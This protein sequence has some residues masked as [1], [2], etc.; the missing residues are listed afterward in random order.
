MKAI[1]ARRHHR[2][3][4]VV[5]LALALLTTGVLYAAFTPGPAQAASAPT[6]DDLTAGN[7]LFRA[8][9]ATCHGMNAQGRPGVAPSL[10]GVGA[11]AVDFQVSTG[12]MPLMNQGA[13][14]PAKPVIFT[15][16]QIRQMAAWVASLGPGP[17]VPAPEEVDPAKGDAAQGM[18]LFR[19]NCAMCHGAVGQGGALTNGKYAPNL[20][21]ASPTTIYEA[22]VTGPQSMPVFNNATIT[23]QEKR[24]II[25][26]LQAQKAGSPG[27]VTLG[28]I[29]PVSEGLWAWLLGIGAL[30]GAAV[31]I[32]AKSS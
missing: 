16:E 31:W 19:T 26:Y 7:N 11:A 1:A 10:I 4:P 15:E 28:S 25:A 27:G 2:F 29:G 14:A 8:N 18:E 21:K 30:I 20:G 13:Q 5:L 24:D 23:P 9:C 17:A 32:G 6:Q 22:M 12:R 3:A